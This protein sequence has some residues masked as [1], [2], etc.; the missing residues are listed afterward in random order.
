MIRD[1]QFVDSN[2]LWVPNT[3]VNNTQLSQII[4][5]QSWLHQA[6]LNQ[7]GYNFGHALHRD[8]HTLVTRFPRKGS[9]LDDYASAMIVDGNISNVGVSPVISSQVNIMLGNHLIKAMTATIELTGKKTPVGRARDAIARFNDSPL[10]VTDAIQQMIYGLHT[11]NRGQP[12]A[13][14]PI[15]MDFSKWEEHGL[16]AIPFPNEGEKP[17]K[18]HLEVDWSKV[19]TP[20]PFLPSPFDLEPTGNKEYPYWYR[21]QRGRND[22]AWVLLHQSHI[23]PVILR[24]SL[25]PGIGTSTLWNLLGVLAEEILIVDRRL[26]ATLNAPGDG[27]IG[28]SG[29]MQGADY[30]KNKVEGTTEDAKAMGNIMYKGTTFI[31]TP[32]SDIKIVKMSLRQDDGVPFEERRAYVEDVI[33][34]AFGDPLSALVIRGGVGYGAQSGTAADAT[35]DSGVGALLHYI[36]TMLGRIYQRVSVSIK[37]PNDRKQRLN[38][39]TFKEFAE[40]IAKINAGSSASGE[41]GGASAP[42]GEPILTREEIRRII[43]RDIFEI[44]DTGTDAGSATPNDNATPDDPIMNAP[45]APLPYTVNDFARHCYRFAPITPDGAGDPLPEPEPDA[46]S[47]DDTQF[48]E[49]FMAYEGMLQAEVMDEEPDD[50]RKDEVWLWILLG[51]YYLRPQSKVDDTVTGRQVTDD[52]LIAI[53]NEMPPLRNLN[54]RQLALDLGAGKITLQQWNTRMKD[55]AQ[56][57][58]VHQ[59]VSRR[60]GFNAMTDA[61]WDQLNGVVGRHYD[62]IDA[63]SRRIGEGRYSVEQISNYSGSIINGTTEASERG[64]ASSYGVTL[65][66]YP[67]DGSTI[68][69]K[70]D[71]CNWFLDQLPGEGNVDAYWQLNPAE[72]CQTCKD[73]ADLWNPLQ[74]RNGTYTTTVPKV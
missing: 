18:Y 41:D 34:A 24:R 50:D 31:T 20:I 39:A 8:E 45:L 48:D 38:I 33:A 65:P 44:P 2:G 43:H 53:R 66:A 57:T 55:N 36:G 54:T 46:K 27:I 25:M 4:H 62:E 63:L 61:D 74:I 37:M 72:N 26:E 6:P 22:Y 52:E 17:K 32:M 30:I 73:R 11:F 19:G 13:T 12:I 23:L 56:M 35:S 42:S 49:D 5:Q 15:T 16:N 29:I 40:G 3:Y 68:C 21:V 69:S 59:Y 67:A 9:G 60:G 10:G 71:K 58:D 7:T 28:I 51:L 64:Y 70:G 1:N 14:V 47:V